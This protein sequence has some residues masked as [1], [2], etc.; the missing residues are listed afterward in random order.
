VKLQAVV[1]IAG[2]LLLGGEM[3]RRAGVPGEVEQ[4]RGD[5][6]LVSTADAQRADL[7]SEDVRMI[8]SDNGSVVFKFGHMTTNRGVVKIGQ[9]DHARSFD[10]QLANGKLVLGVFDYCGDDLVI[11]CAEVGTSRPAGLAPMG[12][13]WVERWR[14]AGP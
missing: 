14:R 7:G 4:L 12:T 2:S 5:W 8:I 9:S 10:L 6:Q 13:Q 11:C 3:P 1:A